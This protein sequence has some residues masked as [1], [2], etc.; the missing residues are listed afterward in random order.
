MIPL[1][2]LF[3]VRYGHSLE[4]NR[5]TL[6]DEKKGGIPFVSRKMGDNGISAYVAPIPNVEPASAGLLTCALSGNGVLSTFLQEQ[7]F[8]TGFHIACL[9]PLLELNKEQLLYYCAC[10]TSNRYRFSYGRQANRTLKN[11]LI[12]SLEQLPD[13]VSNI[14]VD[15]Y[16]GCDEALN[17]HQSEINTKLWRSF[18]YDD[19]FEIKKGQRLTKADMLKGNLPYVGASD[20]FNGITT[21]VGQQAIHKGATITVSYNGSVAE[22]FYQPQPYWATDDV[23]V[24]YPKN[25]ELTS[26]IGLFLCTVIRQEK[27]RF[28]YGRK[29]HLE[30]MRNSIIKLPV[31]LDGSPDW[32]FMEQYIQTLPYSS[33]V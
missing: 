25:F 19:I 15:M 7:S 4:L 29:W 1:S 5:L 6:L 20:S 3:E 8:Y 26:S 31:K 27:Y 22:A 13:Y 32:Q 14:N 21:Y 17:T 9:K 2:D 24:L 30:R 23:N 11:I 33:Q 18:R 10:I 28:N 12:P 16:V